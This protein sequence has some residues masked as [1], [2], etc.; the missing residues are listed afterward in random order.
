MLH[1]LKTWPTPFEAILE[2]R[3]TY[4]LRVDDRNYQVGD[5]LQLREWDG[6]SGYSGR[7][8]TVS[9]TYKTS[10]GEWGLREDLCVLAFRVISK[11]IGTEPPASDVP[12]LALKLQGWA[13]QMAGRFGHPVWLVGSALTKGR[14]ARDIDV[15]IVLP[16][17]EYAARYGPTW[18]RNYYEP[19]TDEKH[20]RWGEDMAKLNRQ[21][22]TVLQMN[23]D[24]QVQS[25]VE[26]TCRHD[27]A[28]RVR[29]DT[30]DLPTE[31]VLRRVAPEDPL[32]PELQGEP[33]DPSSDRGER[34]ALD[35]G[36]GG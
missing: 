35:D 31:D 9:V 33:R 36:E 16:M 10:G 27:G 22:C 21:A 5:T 2:G 18:S 29:L 8:I 6:K 20:K 4:E 25:D 32:N 3:K 13:N 15:R 17:T 1:E 7:T 24:L 12:A 19:W 30:L 26:A 23:V 14:E 34:D 28:P 11:N